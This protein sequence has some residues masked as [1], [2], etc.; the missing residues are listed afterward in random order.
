[1]GK[2]TPKDWQVA[3][4]PWWCPE[5]LQ[6][7]RGCFKWWGANPGL[8]GLAGTNNDGTHDSWVL[9]GTRPPQKKVEVCPEGGKV[10]QKGTSYNQRQ[11]VRIYSLK[12]NQNFCVFFT[13][14]VYVTAKYLGCII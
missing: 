10:I 7:F 2:S 9:K 1:M 13:D 5:F 4:V 6:V 12:Q 14:R 8:P 11:P 3:F